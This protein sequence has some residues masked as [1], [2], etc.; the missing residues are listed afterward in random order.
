VW[1][2]SLPILVLVLLAAA[3][4]LVVIRYMPIILNLFL[5]TEIPKPPPDRRKTEGEKVKFSTADGVTLTGV[6]VRGENSDG[7][8]VVFC[9]EYGSDRNSLRRF[10]DFLPEAG[11]NVF[12]FDFRAHGE[13]ENRDGYVPRQWLTDKELRDLIAAV[14]YVR[15]RTD[16]DAKRIGLFGISRGACACICAAPQLNGIRAIVADGAFSTRITMEQFMRKWV[17]IFA[18]LPVIYENL[19]DWFYTGLGYIG[20]MLA[21]VKLKCRFPPVERYVGRLAPCPIYMIYGERD[22]YIGMAQAKKL[23]EWASNPKELWIVPKAK[24]NE[25]VMTAPQEY[26]SRIAGFFRRHL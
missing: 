7:R 17:S 26:R 14:R 13:S 8:T 16:V 5:N 18:I 2:I 12:A 6:F 22:G 23:F 25:T 24:H 11:I 9:H 10:A 1:L 4:V 15:S 21:E 19:P 20:R 3:G